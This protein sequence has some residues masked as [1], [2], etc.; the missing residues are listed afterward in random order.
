MVAGIP[1]PGWWRRGTV[2]VVVMVIVIV[3]VVH[4]ACQEYQKQPQ[5]S[6]KHRFFHGDLLGEKVCTVDIA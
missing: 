1:V 4:A 5:H 3:F 2:M 6:A